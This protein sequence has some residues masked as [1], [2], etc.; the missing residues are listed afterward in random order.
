MADLRRT[1]TPLREITDP[2]M[3][4]AVS[5]G[6]YIRRVGFGAATSRVTG[7]TVGP[8]GP[9][10][11]TDGVWLC[12]STSVARVC[13]SLPSELAPEQAVPRVRRKVRM[14]QGDTHAVLTHP[15]RTHRHGD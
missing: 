6:P 3:S 2:Y 12:Q 13:C 5:A 15:H 10:C 7:S 4:A 14:K 8:T 1:L 9:T 11:A